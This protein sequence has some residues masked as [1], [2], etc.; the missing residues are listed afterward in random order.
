MQLFTRHRNLLLA[1]LLMAGN[2][3][4]AQPA[5]YDLKEDAAFPNGTLNTPIG[6][7]TFQGGYPS[8]GSIDKLYDA[9]DFQRAS[10]AY[11]W[12]LPLVS[13]ADWKHE[14]R[15]QGASDFDILMM[16]SFKQKQGLLTPNLT[17]PYFI[18]I[19]DMNQ[20]GP[21]VID[22]PAG[23]IAGGVLDFWQRP[24]TE[25]GLTGPD[26]GKGGKYLILPP[27]SE[28]MAPE[29]YTV[30]RSPTMNV[31]LGFRMISP[32][33]KVVLDLA[34]KLRIY[35]Y[36]QRDNPPANQLKQTTEAFWSQT[37]PRGL[38]YWERLAEIINGEPVQE[39]DRMMMA[40]LKPLG[41]E[42]GKAFKPDARQKRILLQGSLVGEAMA[43][44]NAYDKRIEGPFW[45][46]TQWKNA[47]V[48]DYTQEAE[49]YTELDERAAWFYE[50]TTS[51]RGMKITQPGPGQTYITS[52]KDSQG[53]WLDGGKSYKLHLP[54][55]VPAS[56]FWSVTAYSAD[57]RRPIDN[58]T[59]QADLSARMKLA[60]NADGSID[61]YFGPN[62]PQGHEQNWLKTVPGQ[63]WFAY[64][65][66]YGPQQAFFDKTWRLADFQPL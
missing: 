39:R 48:M 45:E 41:I 30:V 5:L 1:T 3:S 15:K 59:Q 28:E 36:A 66:L 53:Q 52:Y 7:L 27:G 21:L 44:A 65:R 14:W 58:Q 24:V 18:T 37:Q 32:D 57:N 6:D 13:V 19:S 38:A 29:G 49:N 35:P 63:G 56:Q 64:L 40:M 2:A 26:Q 23:A 43:K 31:L 12:S 4:A 33:P 47:I 11:L 54:A 22:A 20:T 25:I 9:M 42:K 17:T 60:T 55:N 16:A 46:G 51:S 62:A 61:L 50:A 8:S 34:S 10:Q